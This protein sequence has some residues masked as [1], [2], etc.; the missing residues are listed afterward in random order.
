ME[1][2]IPLSQGELI[3]RARGTL[4]QTAFAKILEVD[5]SCLSRYE[6]ELLGAPTRVV[7][8][9]LRAIAAHA[10]QGGSENTVDMALELARRTVDLLQ[11]AKSQPTPSA[12]APEGI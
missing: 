4:T 10:G 11:R 6:S 2:Q 1:Q 8:Y 7:N 12:P 3:R 5:R 9:C